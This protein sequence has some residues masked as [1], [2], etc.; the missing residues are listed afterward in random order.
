MSSNRFA[1][2]K[3]T[4]VRITVRPGEFRLHGSPGARGHPV[5]VLVGI[6]HHETLEFD[7]DFLGDILQ[8]FAR[9]V[10]GDLF[11]VFNSIR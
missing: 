3:R 8:A 9:I 11:D 7:A 5:R 4:A 1:Q 10:R 6:E 2:R